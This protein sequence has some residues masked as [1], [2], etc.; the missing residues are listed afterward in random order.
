M[1]TLPI[2][3]T[4]TQF[5]T[6]VDPEIVTPPAHDPLYLQTV[7]QDPNVVAFHARSVAD[8]LVKGAKANG[9][10]VPGV[11][12]LTQM[13][14]DIQ[15]ETTI[16]GASTLTVQIIDPFLALLTPDDSGQAFI[17][18]AQDGWLLPIDVNFPQGATDCLWRLCAAEV[19]LALDSANVTLTFEA[20]AASKMREILGGTPQS[21]SFPGELLSLFIQR[22]IGEVDGVNG[23]GLPSIRFISRVMP[24][25]PQV[26]NDNHKLYQP[27]ASAQQK[28]SSQSRKNSE[29]LPSGTAASISQGLQKTTNDVFQK[30]TS[31][32]F[33]SPPPQTAMQPPPRRNLPG[34][35]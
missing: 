19:T 28:H 14:A 31:L 4:G 33:G 21:R 25:P 26:A 15:I 16:T 13:I 18:V 35:P 6:G 9:F 23:D 1:A 17:D 12:D 29:K 11:W 20:A 5:P 22:R 7:L 2:D 8:Q 27:P 34:S 30:I 3:V 32:F 10:Q 24:P